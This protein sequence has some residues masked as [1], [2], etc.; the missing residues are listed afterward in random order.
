MKKCVLAS[1]VAASLLACARESAVPTALLDDPCASGTPY[2]SPPG[3]IDSVLLQADARE[4]GGGG[5]VR[6]LALCLDGAPVLRAGPQAMT[7]HHDTATRHVAA[8]AGTHELTLV[9]YFD[10]T[11]KGARGSETFI[12]RGSHSVDFG[13]ANVVTAYLVDDDP[14]GASFKPRIAWRDRPR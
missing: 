14:G 7:R 12:A 13:S 8:P 5:N 4:L 3:S 9:L 11:A 6:Y 2:V 10:T 1:I